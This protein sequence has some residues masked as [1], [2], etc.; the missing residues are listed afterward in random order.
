MKA[1]GDGLQ[2][3]QHRFVADAKRDRAENDGTGER[4]QFAE[5]AGAQ[6]ETRV[7][8]MAPREQ[9]SESRDRQRGDMRAHVPA[10][11]DQRQRA[12]QRAA[13][14]L[15]DHHHRGERHHAPSAPLVLAVMFAEKG[16]AVFP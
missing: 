7:N 1:N 3:P 12:E 4:R 11:G 5:L 9:I 10:V 16:V 6:R 15:D 13:G 2:E 8:R 14:N